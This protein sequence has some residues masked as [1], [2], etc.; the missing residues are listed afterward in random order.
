[1]LTANQARALRDAMTKQHVEVDLYKILKD[2]AEQ[3]IDPKSRNYIYADIDYVDEK[4]DLIVNRLRGM[5]YE[6]EVSKY[7]EDR[8]SSLTVRF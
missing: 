4:V 1:M 3:A 2:I 5:G 7:P 8:Y 6:V